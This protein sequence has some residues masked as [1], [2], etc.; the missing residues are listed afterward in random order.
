MLATPYDAVTFQHVHEAQRSL[1]FEE[2]GQS[3]TIRGDEPSAIPAESGAPAI[4]SPQGGCS[5]RPY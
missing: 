2:E 4:G 1:E 5:F 3:P